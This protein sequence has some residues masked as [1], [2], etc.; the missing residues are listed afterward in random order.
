MGMVLGILD[1]FKHV[2]G[3]LEASK[4][5]IGDQLQTINNSLVDKNN[6]VNILKDAN[7]LF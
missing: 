6:L 4:I 2:A 5:L 7:F 1:E 3:R